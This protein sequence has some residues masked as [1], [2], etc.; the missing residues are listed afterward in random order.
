MDERKE[1]SISEA[2]ELS[3]IVK[4]CADAPGYVLFVG[5]LSK[6][7]DTDGNMTINFKYRRSRFLLEDVA[8]AVVA[9]KQ[10]MIKDLERRG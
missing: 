4:E 6:H 10:H 9:F 5:I 3:G 8:K 7:K 1:A 2:G